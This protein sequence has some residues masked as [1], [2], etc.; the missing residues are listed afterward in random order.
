MGFMHSPTIFIACLVAMVFFGAM[1]WVAFYITRHRLDTNNPA[2]VEADAAATTMEIA[3]RERPFL[4][5]DPEQLHP[6][7]YCV[8][9]LECPPPSY[10]AVFSRNT[11]PTQQEMR[12]L[13]RRLE[14]LQQRRASAGT[15]SAPGSPSSSAAGSSSSSSRS[16][17]G[18]NTNAATNTPNCDEAIRDSEIRCLRQWIDRLETL[19]EEDD[20][21]VFGTR[22]TMRVVSSRSE[23][24]ALPARAATVQRETGWVGCGLPRE[25]LPP[26]QPPPSPSLSES[27]EIRF[28]ELREQVLRG[29]RGRYSMPTIR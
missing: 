17:S 5:G 15:S 9:D 10:Q 19:R 18:V 24:A 20:Q 22:R 29:M 12:T 14:K 4:H 26:Y 8:D 16:V 23:P 1:I 7:V 25:I 28:G 13:H 6:P 27:M 11:A 21:P 2:D 3:R